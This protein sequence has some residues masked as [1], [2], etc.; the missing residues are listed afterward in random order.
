MG[1]ED[2]EKDT[3]EAEDGTKETKEDSAPQGEIAELIRT[4]TD[5]VKMVHRIL[6]PVDPEAEELIDRLM[7]RRRGNVKT[8][9]LTRRRITRKG[10]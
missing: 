5:H 8:R 2:T 1:N 10:E 4:A 3:K 6:P 7:A 9:P